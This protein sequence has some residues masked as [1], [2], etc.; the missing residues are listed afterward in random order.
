MEQIKATGII[1]KS[2]DNIRGNIVYIVDVEINGTIVRAES[3][4]YSLKT[5]ELRAGTK[6]D[7][8]YWERQDGSKAVEILD[9][10]IIACKDDMGGEL[11]LLI[12]FVI[13]VVVVIV[14][15]S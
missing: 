1:N 8:L 2:Y 4:D 5:K 9:D 13:L 11:R 12:G 6:V 3:I 7:V 15:T 10:R 14:V